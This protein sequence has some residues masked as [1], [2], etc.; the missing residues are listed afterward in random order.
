M[1]VLETLGF[2]IF[3]NRES[4]A[5]NEYILYDKKRNS[6][7]QYSEKRIKGF[8]VKELEN[9]NVSLYDLFKIVYG[10]DIVKLDTED[11]QL[12]INPNKKLAE[13]I[14]KECILIDG[15]KFKPIDDILFIDNIDK[16]TYFN[17]FK[18]P[19]SFK[20]INSKI[21]NTF[22]NKFDWFKNNCSYHYKLL[23]NLHSNNELAVADTLMKISDKLKYPDKKAQ[24]II[25]F[26]PGE[27][28]GKGIF[29]KYVL[30]P[31]FEKYAKKTLMS[32]L[33]SDF[34]A[35]LTET[36]I[37]VLEEGKRDA[38]LIETLKEATTESTILINEKGKN[39]RQEQIYFLSFVF[40]NN[41]NPIDLGKS[42][43][44]Y[45]I[46][47]PLGN[48]WD[49][50]QEKGK[51]LVN[52]LPNETQDFIKYLYS[53]D[54]EH[55]DALLP[56]QTEA[57]DNVNDLNKSPLEL[58][59]DRLLSFPTLENSLT[60]LYYE[61]FGVSDLNLNLKTIKNNIY[62]S[63]DIIRESYNNFC[64]SSGF[65]SNLITHNKDLVQLWS[66]FNM[67]DETPKRITLNSGRKIDH[68]NLLKINAHIKEQYNLL[69]KED[70][71]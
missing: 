25:I 30:Q 61:R 49:K 42:R 67:A 45:H 58:F 46:C 41:M 21:D 18:A 34:N 64:K 38:D 12:L 7:N 71:E 55:Q 47:K 3:K 68:I 27:R 52:N 39:Q 69:E 14:N 19:N 13:L 59:Y 62:I 70:I 48:N 16:K 63:K 4:S 24:D 36:L 17:T 28:A 56:F 53:L 44:S 2:M 32:K 10:E 8:L 29:F 33:N 37:L 20:L 66:L 23:M 60:D 57:K 35:F 6:Y 65:K 31:I 50:C 26:Y 11:K 9:V 54:F 5:E 43:G 40:S 15:I 1:G 22:D 51:E